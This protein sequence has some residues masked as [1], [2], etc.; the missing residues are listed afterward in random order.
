LKDF[1]VYFS[2]MPQTGYCTDVTCNKKLTEL[3]ECHC[4]SWLIC[5]K[6]LLE[7]VEVSKRDKKIQ[8]DSIRNELISISYT[9]ELIVEKKMYEIETEKQ[10]INQAKIIIDKSE[11][12]IEEIQLIS[13]EI[14][15]AILS[16]R[17]GK[18]I[19]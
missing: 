2:D 17:K 9:L 19:F 1:I 13:E 8:L 16:N 4:C 18:R 15:Q 11:H 14:N 6:H 7:H 5:L 10:L 3:Y 12:T